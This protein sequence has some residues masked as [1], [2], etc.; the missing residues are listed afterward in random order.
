V[1]ASNEVMCI[2]LTQ[3]SMPT[4]LLLLLWHLSANSSVY[5][6]GNRRSTKNKLGRNKQ[7]ER[8]QS[9]RTD[10]ST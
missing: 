1:R 2:A 8:Q 9:E 5:I 10:S 7:R 4:Q 3:L 6:I